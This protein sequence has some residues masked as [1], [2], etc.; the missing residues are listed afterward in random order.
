MKLTTQRSRVTFQHELQ[1]SAD[2]GLLGS[3][4]AN[5]GD[6]QNG[7][8]TDQFPINIYELVEAMLVLLPAGGVQGGGINFDAKTRRNSTDLEDMFLA[9]IGGMDAFARALLIAHNMLENSPYSAWRKDRYQ[10]FD[11]GN[12]KA[13][14]NGELSLQQ[15]HAIA[16][17]TGEPPMI[18]GKQELY[19][20]LINQFI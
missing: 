11:S 1:V 8:D 4:D 16:M 15:L 20:N 18:S 13:F 10:T 19:E 6:Y 9:H 3:I 12:G 5:R 14:E 2:A 17:E 7:W